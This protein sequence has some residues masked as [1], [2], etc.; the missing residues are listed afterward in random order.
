MVVRISTEEYSGR[1]PASVADLLNDAD[2]LPD[3]CP[4][5]KN[6]NPDELMC[7]EIIHF[8]LTQI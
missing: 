8:S 3:T 2:E 5:L 1:F 4:I 6:Q 7:N